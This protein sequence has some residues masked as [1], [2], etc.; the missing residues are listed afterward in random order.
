[1]LVCFDDSNFNL[2]QFLLFFRQLLNDKRLSHSFLRG[3]IRPKK[4][5][6]FNL[7]EL[8]NSLSKLNRKGHFRTIAKVIPSDKENASDLV[9]EVSEIAN[10]LQVMPQVNNQGRP[11]VGI[12]RTGASVIFYSPLGRTDTLTLNTSVASKTL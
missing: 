1:M 6:V 7:N 4:G 2:S 12:V 10:L 5:E 9:L 11:N 3:Q 8:E